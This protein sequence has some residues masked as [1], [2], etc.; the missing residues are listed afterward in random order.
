MFVYGEQ[1]V[2]LQVILLIMFC[3]QKPV[4]QLARWTTS[5]SS[6]SGP[7]EHENM[8]QKFIQKFTISAV[9]KE[10]IGSFPDSSPNTTE[11]LFQCLIQWVKNKI[12]KNLSLLFTNYMIS[13]AWCVLHWECRGEKLWFILQIFSQTMNTQSDKHPRRCNQISAVPHL[14]EVLTRLYL[15]KLNWKASL[16]SSRS[17]LRLIISEDNL[18]YSVFNHVQN[19]F[20]TRVWLYG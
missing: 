15:R 7:I 1:C 6:S 5:G 20:N 10:K 17:W 18:L 19:S 13:Y 2:L 8:Q 4:V 3:S 12:K 14:T 9:N 11:P 16:M